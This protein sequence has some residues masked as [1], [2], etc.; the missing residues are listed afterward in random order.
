MSNINDKQKYLKYKSKY[1]KKKIELNN[2]LDFLNSNMSN[3]RI[4]SQKG[5]DYTKEFTTILNNGVI[6]DNNG[7]K[8]TYQC[9]WITIWHYLTYF[10]EDENYKD[11]FLRYKNP[12]NNKI[13]RINIKNTSVIQIKLLIKEMLSFI[14]TNWDSIDR[15]FKIIGDDIEYYRTAYDSVNGDDTMLDIYQNSP[16]I[17]YLQRF[18]N[19]H[20]IAHT[21][22]KEEVKEEEEV[23]R[24]KK[25]FK[26][27]I[28]GL[29][30]DGNITPSPRVI[31]IY[32]N[33]IHFEL[34][35]K[36]NEIDLYKE[37]KI[38]LIPSKELHNP[39]KDVKSQIE[40]D[41][42]LAIRLQQQEE[43]SP[44][45][46]SSRSEAFGRLEAPRRPRRHIGDLLTEDEMLEESI[47]YRKNHLISMIIDHLVDEKTNKEV[48]T[49]ALQSIILPKLDIKQLEKITT[50]LNLND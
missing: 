34:L 46:A 25:I 23:A 41:E 16:L 45:K 33:N 17:L 24:L 5:G 37:K 31:Q 43:Y 30:D 9:F 28:V 19:V 42:E 44:I 2:S 8:Y 35:I 12:I 13:F 3:S 14:T 6:F 29:I 18:L 40:R 4:K 48:L 11:N 36:I 1:L 50:N 21:L 38:A 22:R 27:K 20:I 39:L 32:C 15:S 47:Q 26:E 49:E 7:E 10:Y